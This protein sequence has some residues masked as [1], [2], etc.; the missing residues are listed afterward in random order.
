LANIIEISTNEK[1]LL[2]CYVNNPDTLVLSE[3]NN[4][5]SEIGKNYYE[6]LC[7][8]KREGLSFSTDNIIKYG[9]SVNK[10]NL[11]PE[12]LSR[13]LEAKA[14]REE[15]D[16]YKASQKKYFII[17]K[18]QSE[19]LKKIATE[20]Y[21]KGDISV[22]ELTKL[23]EE[24]RSLLREIDT[25]KV[26]TF[27]MTDAMDKYIPMVEERLRGTRKYSSGDPYL[28]KELYNESL[29]PGQISIV[30]GHPGSG[31][32]TFVH[33]LIVKRLV[34]RLPTLY[35]A[36]EMDFESTMDALVAN[37]SDMTTG[38]LTGSVFPTG[39]APEYVIEK[40][41]GV[42]KRFIRNRN[43]AYTD[44][45]GLSVARLEKLIAT[46]KDSLGLKQDDYLFVAIDL[47]TMLKDFGRAKADEIEY[48]M[49]QIHELAKKTNTHIMGV[50]QARRNERMIITE[51]DDLER[52]RPTLEQIKN[53]GAIE[54]RS[55]IILGVYRMKH[56]MKKYMPDAPE[57]AVTDDI[58]E[59]QILKQNN[60]DVGVILKYLFIPEKRKL[61]KLKE[62]EE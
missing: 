33:G 45:Q 53:S 20:S 23:N 52:F 49:N 56:F 39:E 37:L 17:D 14:V 28:D 36:T 54:E 57:L 60:A 21:R 15:L 3:E 18:I 5:I 13:I 27:S 22:D 40:V 16:S 4:F 10:E 9:Q 8:L 62:R 34:K 24:M 31:K 30:F 6:T 41:R 2:A 11:K 42:R 55:R 50:V 59:I 25:R 26:D 32:S 19:I 61:M 58:M 48:G 43:F 1:Q 47:L 35:V 46:T 29:M 7:I 38:E 51:V 12:I 44:T